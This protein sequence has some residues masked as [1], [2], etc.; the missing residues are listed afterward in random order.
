VSRPASIVV[1]KRQLDELYA[2]LPALDC[3]R[4]CQDSCG[5]IAMSYVE[6]ARIV[7]KLGYEPRATGAVCPLLRA[8]LCSVYPVRPMLCR[9]WGLVETMQCPWGCVPERVLTT[10]EGYVFLARARAI[11]AVDDEE[12]EEAADALATLERTPDAV[13]KLSEMIHRRPTLPLHSQR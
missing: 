12:Y 3:Q 1:A 10:R 7:K 4:R 9:L 6:W 2:E 11:G 13:V 5:P 8:G